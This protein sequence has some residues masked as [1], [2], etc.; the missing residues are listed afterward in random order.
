[1]F[2]M[3]SKVLTLKILIFNVVNFTSIRDK[4]NL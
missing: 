4:T 1:M 2:K 3:V